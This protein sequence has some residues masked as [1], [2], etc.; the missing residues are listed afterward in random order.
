MPLDK[1]K[2]RAMIREK[3]GLRKADL[4]QYFRSNYKV[5]IEGVEVDFC[6]KVMEFGLIMVKQLIL[7]KNTGFS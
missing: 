6:P 1:E 4:A 3:A 2:I 5:T 7:V